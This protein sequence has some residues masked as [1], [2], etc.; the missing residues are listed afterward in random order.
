MPCLVERT[1][2][3]FPPPASFC[4]N[5]HLPR[6]PAGAPASSPA[7]EPR[8]SKAAEDR[9]APLA[10]SCPQGSSAFWS[11]ASSRR[12][13]CFGDSSPKQACV[14]RPADETRPLSRDDA[15][16]D[17]RKDAKAQRRKGKQSSRD[18]FGVTEVSPSICAFVCVFLA[19][20][21][22]CA[23]ALNRTAW[24]RRSKFDGDKSP[25]R[26]R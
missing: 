20:P 15:E 11:A 4:G 2:L 9:G 7:F 13:G 25:A 19:P 5:L 1:R 21:R 16:G 17:Q 26:K 6:A 18:R 3:Q 12:F 22:L 14:Q 8:P 24:I 10:G 23:F